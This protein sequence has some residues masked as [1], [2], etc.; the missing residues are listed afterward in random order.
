MGSI[1]WVMLGG[2]IIIITIIIITM[3]MPSSTPV[4]F[5]RVRD[6]CRLRRGPSGRGVGVRPPT[7][8]VL[9]CF[10]GM[11]S[12]VSA[13]DALRKRLS[14]NNLAPSQWTIYSCGSCCFY[15][16]YLAAPSHFVFLLPVRV[17]LL[18]SLIM[19]FCLYDYTKSSPCFVYIFFLFTFYVSLD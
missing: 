4:M 14:R 10:H 12:C 7:T 3:V 5:P 17:S 16:H 13:L 8:V 2:V 19:T 11:E 6:L 1:Q 18:C 9:G 15:L